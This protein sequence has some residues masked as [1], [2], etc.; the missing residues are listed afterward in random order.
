MPAINLTKII[1]ETF[2][3]ISNVSL[4]T[5]KCSFN[6]RVKIERKVHY[7]NSNIKVAQTY[8]QRIYTNTHI[9]YIHTHARAHA[10][11][12]AHHKQTRMYTY[13]HIHTHIHS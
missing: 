11:T 1:K 10:R 7:Y 9:Q 4:Y 6:Y 13:I 5:Q 8:I 2:E 3:L 12:R